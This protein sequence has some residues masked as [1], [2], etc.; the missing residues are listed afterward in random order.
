MS[1]RSE[2][3]LFIFYF[4]RCH[5]KCVSRNTVQMADRSQ[6]ST[7]LTDY[8]GLFGGLHEVL[9]MQANAV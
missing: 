2:S 3:V 6:T 1:D 5:A 7:G 8:V 9:T 4:K